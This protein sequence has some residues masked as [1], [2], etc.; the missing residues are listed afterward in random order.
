MAT[1]PLTW[2]MKSWLVHRHP[3]F[4]AYG[5]IPYITGYYFIRGPTTS[6]HSQR[7]WSTLSNL[8]WYP[9]KGWSKIPIDSAI[10]QPI[11]KNL[12]SAKG[13]LEVGTATNLQRKWWVKS[14][15]LDDDFYPYDEYWWNSETNL[16][17]IGGRLDFQGY[18]SQRIIISVQCLVVCLPR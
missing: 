15:L 8:C 7:F 2:T 1:K 3:C 10:C 11:L 12:T 6:K 14:V 13:A 5:I 17:K 18:V 4:M 9:P 16:L